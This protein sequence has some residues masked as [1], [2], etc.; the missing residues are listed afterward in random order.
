MRNY[1]MKLTFAGGISSTLRF[2]HEY[3]RC[4]YYNLTWTPGSYG[5]DSY[6]S[7]NVYE[8]S[9]QRYSVFFQ[10]FTI[11]PNTY[12]GQEEFSALDWR[13]SAIAV[14]LPNTVVEIQG[15]QIHIGGYTLVNIRTGD[16]IE[17]LAE[18]WKPNNTK[19]E[20]VWLPVATTDPKVT[21]SQTS[22]KN[23]YSFD[24]TFT[25]LPY[26]EFGAQLR[27]TR[28]QYLAL[29]FVQ[30][31]NEDTGIYEG[32]VI[33]G[34]TYYH[35]TRPASHNANI[36]LFTMGYNTI[37]LGTTALDLQL[38]LTIPIRTCKLDTTL[39]KTAEADVQPLIDKV[40]DLTVQLNSLSNEFIKF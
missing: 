15:R 3:S 37:D 38:D 20:Y 21:I 12:V 7:K 33:S 14:G 24:D 40:R 22:D 28:L 29:S 39:L 13:V 26:I 31:Y 5:F 36:Q 9:A 11:K 2:R 16:V 1:V 27:I 23:T 34:E 4:P 10:S 25:P 17:L 6:L 30:Q 35:D 18:D 32:L 19:L 8:T